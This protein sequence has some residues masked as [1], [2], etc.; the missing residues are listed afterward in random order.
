M[1][2]ARPVTWVSRKIKKRSETMTV[3]KQ[4]EIDKIVGFKQETV[5]SDWNLEPPAMTREE[6]DSIIQAFRTGK[7]SAERKNG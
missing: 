5:R 4:I 1:Q 2:P 7:V 3:L 6:L